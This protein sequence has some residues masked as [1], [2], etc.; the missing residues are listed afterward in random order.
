MPQQS[1][2]ESKFASI[3]GQ[4]RLITLRNSQNA[5]VT[6]TISAPADR[7]DIAVVK[8]VLVGGGCRP[9]PSGLRLRRSKG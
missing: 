4:V 9:K 3:E 2:F 6:E 7:P 8:R 1:E 5:A